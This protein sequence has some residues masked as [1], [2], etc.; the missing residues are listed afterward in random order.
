MASREPSDEGPGVATRETS[1]VGPG[2]AT[3]E[4]SCVGPGVAT[5]GVG[6]SVVVIQDTS[7]ERLGHSSRMDALG[8]TSARSTKPRFPRSKSGNFV[9]NF[10][11]FETT[12]AA[13]N[14]SHRIPAGT[15]R[16]GTR[17]SRCWWHT[18]IHVVRLLLFATITETPLVTDGVLEP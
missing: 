6:A 13:A 15:L 2:V 18:A 3:R 5:A 14:V 8:S 4:L 9:C 1:G 17:G 7:S 12:M 10:A 16:T 11:W